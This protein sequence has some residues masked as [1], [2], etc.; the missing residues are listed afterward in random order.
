M[1][2]AGKAANND[3]VRDVEVMVTESKAV[4]EEGDVPM[5]GF[6]TRDLPCGPNVSAWV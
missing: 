2:G 1:K 5:R 3:M 4:A 6:S